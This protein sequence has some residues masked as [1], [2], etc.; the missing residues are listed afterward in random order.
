MSKPISELNYVADYEPYLVPYLQQMIKHLHLFGDIHNQQK[1][2]FTIGMI[3][4][5]LINSGVPTIPPSL[6]PQSSS[7][8]SMSAPSLSSS[9][10]NGQSS[11]QPDVTF[12][13]CWF[14]HKQKVPLLGLFDGLS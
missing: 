14:L 9:I 10:F 7:S 8:T 4:N 12:P 6:H 13:C 3:Y 11:S 5:L 2:P 1:L